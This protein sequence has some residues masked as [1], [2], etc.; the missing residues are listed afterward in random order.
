MA[1]CWAR[2]VWP[3]SPAR[4]AGGPGVRAGADCRV[5]SFL[6]EW[7]LVSLILIVCGFLDSRPGVSLATDTR[8]SCDGPLQACVLGG[9]V[10]GWM[11]ALEELETARP[12]WSRRPRDVVPTG[13]SLAA[14]GAALSRLGTEAGDSGR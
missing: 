4:S 9:G 1:A 14:G 10:G 11:A 5:T 3:L 2:G 12:F 7:A 8:G 6:A 13:V